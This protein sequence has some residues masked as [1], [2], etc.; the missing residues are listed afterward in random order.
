[1]DSNINV[2][3]EVNHK[4]V[5][6][7]VDLND[8]ELSLDIRKEILQAIRKKKELT[9]KELENGKVPQKEDSHAAI[10]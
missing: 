2:N 3:G 9:S 6:G 8:L 10:S 7:H 4:H 5:H 1:M